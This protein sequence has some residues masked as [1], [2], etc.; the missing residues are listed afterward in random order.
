MIQ[1]E[2]VFF[3]GDL[4]HSKY[5][6]DFLLLEDLIRKHPLKKF[7]LILG[8]HDILDPSTY[9]GMGMIVHHD[10]LSLGP[11]I[12]SHEPTEFESGYNLAGHIHPGV[13]L[14]GQGKQS[15]RAACFHFGKDKGLL[16]AF[17]SLTGLH[18]IPV[19]KGDKVYLVVEGR[20]IPAQ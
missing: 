13:K 6:A 8:N 12:M 15:L 11:F 4:F 3:L 10:H 14:K 16:P 1:L 18:T 19:K 20:V 17:G 9:K 5:N 7:E 2:R